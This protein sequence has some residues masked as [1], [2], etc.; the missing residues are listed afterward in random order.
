M[1]SNTFHPS[2]SLDSQITFVQAVLLMYMY[3]GGD[4]CVCAVAVVVFLLSVCEYAHG[5]FFVVVDVWGG[6]EGRPGSSDVSPL[7]GISGMPV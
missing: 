2:D 4:V 3:T 6:P 5:L 1:L 7:S